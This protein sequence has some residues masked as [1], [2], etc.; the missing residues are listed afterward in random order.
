MQRHTSVTYWDTKIKRTNLR[1]IEGK[2]L[3]RYLDKVYTKLVA[4]HRVDE[5]VKVN[6]VRRMKVSIAINKNRYKVIN[7]RHLKKSIT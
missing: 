7:V 2:A 1:S 3:I 5:P 6:H 4:C